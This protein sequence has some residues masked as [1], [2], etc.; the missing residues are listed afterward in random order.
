MLRRRLPNSPDR[1]P[2]PRLNQ[3]MTFDPITTERLLIRSPVA[4]DAGPLH[5]RRN[6][7][8]V[9]RFQNWTLPFPESRADE[10][11]SASV[12]QGGPADGEWWMATVVERSSEEAIGD[13]A[14]H[15]A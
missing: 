14:L 15:A 9:A 7:P 5:A 8:E 4:A 10:L 3:R 12:E 13:L 2:E 6:Q 11:I 1:R